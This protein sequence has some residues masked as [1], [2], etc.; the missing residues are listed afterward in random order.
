M[1]T[2]LGT[3]EIQTACLIVTAALAIGATVTIHAAHEEW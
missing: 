3:K 2:P 1:I